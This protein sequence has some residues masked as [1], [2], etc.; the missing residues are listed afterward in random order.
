MNTRAGIR[1]RTPTPVAGSTALIYVPPEV[2]E[3]I[4]KHFREGEPIV[5]IEG[6][7]KEKVIKRTIRFDLE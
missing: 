3:R 5:Y 1:P 7:P 6:K 2:Q 4:K